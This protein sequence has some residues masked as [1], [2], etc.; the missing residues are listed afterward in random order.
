M[1][2]VLLDLMLYYWQ[3]QDKLVDY[4]CFQILYQELVTGKLADKRCPIVSD[5]IPHLLQ[6]KINDGWDFVSYEEAFAKGNIHKMS[7]F[8]EDAMEKLRKLV[9]NG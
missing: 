8:D 5:V 3:T 7:Y 9:I 6:T 1:I 4:F 2:A